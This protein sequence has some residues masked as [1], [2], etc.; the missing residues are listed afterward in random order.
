MLSLQPISERHASAS[1]QE[2]YHD[3]KLSLGVV[4]VPV[5]FQYI[6]N[7]EDALIYLWQHMKKGVLSEKFQEACDQMIRNALQIVVDV[8]KP[9]FDCIEYIHHMPIAEKEEKSQDALKLLQTQAKMLLI[10]IQIR[11]AIKGMPIVGNKIKAFLHASE[12]TTSPDSNNTSIISNQALAFVIQSEFEYDSFF[13]RINRE[14]AHLIAQKKY[15]EGRVTF[16]KNVQFALLQGALPLEIDYRVFREL[17][18]GKSY[19]PECLFLLKD[20]FPS[21]APRQLFT[22]A[23]MNYILNLD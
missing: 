9:S 8:Y 16:E 13:E 19:A 1:I 20:V 17:L 11:E 4:S 3:I 5:Y 18:V 21:N 2:V 12:R 10:E 7:Y 15:L 22:A 23:L 14:V 6:A